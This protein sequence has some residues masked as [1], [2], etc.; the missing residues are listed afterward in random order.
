MAAAAHRYLQLLGEN[1]PI[2]ILSATPARLED[3]L[4][5][6]SEADLDD[7]A[8]PLPPE[9]SRPGSTPEPVWTPRLLLANLADYELVTGFRLR[10]LIALP[11]IEV[12]AVDHD[13]WSR[14]YQRLAPSLALEAFR[15]LRSWNL[16]LLAGFSLEDWLAEGFDPERGFE[17]CD[18]LVRQL[19]GHDLECLVRLGTDSHGAGS[20]SSSR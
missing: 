4:A 2:E 19:A 5:G 8:A 10:Q 3:W 6:V 9:A 12:Q 1:D 13:L 11:G 14:R 17:S 16:A 15:A 7:P 18:L 20:R